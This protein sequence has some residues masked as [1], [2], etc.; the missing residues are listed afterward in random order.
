MRKGMFGI[1]DSENENSV[2]L[3]YKKRNDIYR[4]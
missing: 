1:K 4:E 3:V 2:L